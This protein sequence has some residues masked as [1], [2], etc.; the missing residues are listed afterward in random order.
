MFVYIYQKSNLN[1]DL[2]LTPRACFSYSFN[3]RPW[4]FSLL[5]LVQHFRDWDI[6]LFTGRKLKWIKMYGAVRSVLADVDPE[7][8]S[9]AHEKQSK[10]IKS[11]IYIYRV[12]EPAE[13]DL[14]V[15]CTDVCMVPQLLYCNNLTNGSTLLFWP[16]AFP[17][18]PA[19]FLVFF[20]F[21][22]ESTPSIKLP[23]L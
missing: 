23:D 19:F 9:P 6:F 3:T 18:A 5:P 14:K 4:S 2:S 13:I 8:L 12:A 10:A 21:L 22:I 17:L 20:F 7:G 15:L 16:F 11:W 1:V